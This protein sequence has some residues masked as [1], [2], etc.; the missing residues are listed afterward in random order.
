MREDY[1]IRRDKRRIAGSIIESTCNTVD[2]E[3]RNAERAS[4]KKFQDDSLKEIVKEN[5]L[6][7]VK[8]KIAEK[9]ALDEI[10]SLLSDENSKM[11]CEILQV[12]IKRTES[13]V[14]IKDMKA[15]K[16]IQGGQDCRLINPKKISLEKSIIR[17]FKDIVSGLAAN[18]DKAALESI[19]VDIDPENR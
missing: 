17:L 4:Q 6:Y 18:R 13:T 5:F 1:K 9:I 8:K 2:V 11:H 7:Q 19:A 14:K 15:E 16:K 12:V 10:I 3:K